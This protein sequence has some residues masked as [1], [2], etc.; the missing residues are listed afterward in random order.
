M[1]FNQI[2]AAVALLA[3]GSAFAGSTTA[4]TAYSS[5]ASASKGNLAVA[6]A[7]MCAAPKVFVEFKSGSNIST[8]FCAAAGSSFSAT[9]TAAEYTAATPALFVNPTTAAATAYSELRLNV[10]GGSF[11]AVC[12]LAGWPT[13]TSCPAADTYLDP[14]TGTL[15]VAPPTTATTGK[16]VGGLMDVEP[17]GFLSTI[18]SGIANPS[19]VTSANFAQT[20]GVAVSNDLYS[21]MFADQQAS[22]AL[23]P[24]TVCAVADTKRAE[25]VP[26][27]GKAQM[28][29]IMSSIST[30]DAYTKGAAFLAPSLT[31]PT[32]MTY[33]RR[34]DTSGTQAAAQQYFL[35]NVCNSSPVPVVGAGA[36]NGAITVTALSS[37]GG[38]RNLLNGVNSS[39]ASIGSPNYAIAV[40][41]GEN[42]QASD[43]VNNITVPTTW[44]WL[45]VGGTAVADSAAPKEAGVTFSNTATAKDGRYDFWFVSRVVAPATA[46]NSTAAAFW[47][48]VKA[49]FANVPQ[50]NTVGLFATNETNFSK[51]SSCNPVNQ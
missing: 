39:G 37:T 9:P 22:G 51:S 29:A 11:T 12:P 47:N 48:A 16:I 21:A 19:S 7:S 10:A 23:P 27:I 49:A 43:T 1:K 2:T 31:N 50:N 46:V 44:K 14:A 34:G 36:S 33:G 17:A 25:C 40:I 13:G 38:V 5:G 3:V 30:N 20:F 8:Y 24:S 18:R 45:R 26:V 4:Q 15:A 35:G 32:P 6:L 42:N 28:A 41:S